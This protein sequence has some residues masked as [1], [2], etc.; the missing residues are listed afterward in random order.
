MLHCS[1][2][3]YRIKCY[4]SYSVDFTRKGIQLDATQIFYQ[5]TDSFKH[6]LT[7]TKLILI[8]LLHYLPCL[9]YNMM[10]KRYFLLFAI[11]VSL[12]LLSCFIHENMKGFTF[13]DIEYYK[14]A[15]AVN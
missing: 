13:V 10:I 1:H 5:G 7:I 4:I 6:F 2:G 3:K 15:I 9:L 11:E 8:G 14:F 12:V